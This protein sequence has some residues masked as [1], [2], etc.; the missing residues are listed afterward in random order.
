[1][2]RAEIKGI[3]EEL[4]KNIIAGNDSLPDQELIA[5]VK[6]KKKKDY[7]MFLDIAPFESRHSV[8]ISAAMFDKI[9]LLT[10]LLGNKLTIGMFVN[11][12]LKQHFE[13]HEGEINTI[14][15]QQI[16]KLKP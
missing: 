3:D 11:N 2:S 1:M 4:I 14:I 15:S 10:R 16:K 5:E 8:Y 13:Q 9:S 12:I 7:S 6:S